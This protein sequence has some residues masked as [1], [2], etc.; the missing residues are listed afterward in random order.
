MYFVP[1]NILLLRISAPDKGLDGTLRK[2]T[3]MAI[4]AGTIL[5]IQYMVIVKCIETRSLYYHA[6][7]VHCKYKLRPHIHASPGRRCALMKDKGRPQLMLHCKM[8]SS[9]HIFELLVSKLH[10]SEKG[11]RT[12]AEGVWNPA[13]VQRRRGSVAGYQVKT[14]RS[15]ALRGNAAL[16]SHILASP[17]TIPCFRRLSSPP[18]TKL[19]IRTFG[20]PSHQS[21]A[22]KPPCYAITHFLLEPASRLAQN[23]EFKGWV[24]RTIRKC[25]PVGC[26]GVFSSHSP[27]SER[28]PPLPAITRFLL[29]TASRLARIAEIKGWVG[30]PWLAVVGKMVADMTGEREG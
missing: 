14:H 16:T 18:S 20:G 30:I 4:Q 6:L 3:G 23:I 21:S 5:P 15:R 7:P 27:L 10:T 11:R 29:D 9:V 12:V 24:V 26:G 19:D 1:G 17:S 25:H 2:K 22:R 28:R 8:F 13:R